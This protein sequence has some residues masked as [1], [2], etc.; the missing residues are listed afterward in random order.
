MQRFP[1]WGPTLRD[2]NDIVDWYED[3]SDP[4]F[5]WSYHTAVAPVGRPMATM[6]YYGNDGEI[7]TIPA[8][9]SP[10]P[11][12]VALTM[13]RPRLGDLV[14]FTVDG[15]DGLVCTFRIADGD[16]SQPPQFVFE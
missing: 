11:Y 7:Y 15:Q 5:G 10:P 14:H 4:E 16:D 2:P 1:F 6:T 3:E 8:D 13:P 12:E 9:G